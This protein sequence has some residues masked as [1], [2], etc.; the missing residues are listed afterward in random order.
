[1][2]INS[3]AINSATVNGA[4]VVNIFGT[5]SNTLSLVTTVSPVT[6]MFVNDVL[7]L[8]ADED[9][10]FLFTLENNISVNTDTSSVAIAKNTVS[11]N[12]T[13]LGSIRVILSAVASETIS[14]ATG[15][16][17]IIKQIEI[18]VDRILLVETNSE[19]LIAISTINNL[20][21]IIDSIGFNTVESISD[22]LSIIGSISQLHKA[23]SSL[24]NTL[25]IATAISEH[26]IGIISLSNDISIDDDNSTFV[27][28]I[29]TISESFIITTSKVGGGSSYIAYLLSPEGNS[30]T[31][32]DNYNFNLCTKY[33]NNYLFANSSGL[34][35][36]GGVTDAGSTIRAVIETIAYSFGDSN[37]KQVPSIYL[38]VTN[39]STFLLK[40]R[41]D[42]KAEVTYKMRKRTMGLDTQ[43]VDIG[44]G[45]IGRYFQ[46]ELITEAD[47]FEM[48]SIEFFPLFIRRKI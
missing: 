44:K 18:L 17:D 35:E 9:V 27:D 47:D 5:I 39:S 23:L 46:F 19:K 38:G 28:F 22:V 21:N 20:L 6:I 1:M 12:A 26:T 11:E 48:E 24:N 32:Y 15:I 31:N 37:K 3:G 41:V 36:F 30:V 25:S 14:I 8:I 34:Y 45:L 29:N 42:G 33:G 16:S 10:T 7:N 13:V 4:S 43:K 2:S 40:V